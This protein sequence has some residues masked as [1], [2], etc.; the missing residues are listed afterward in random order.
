MHTQST[1]KHFSS[2]VG[3]S[4]I[5]NTHLCNDSERKRHIMV[6]RPRR[7]WSYW[8]H[9]Q[10]IRLLSAVGNSIFRHVYWSS[11]SERLPG[12]PTTWKYGEQSVWS[13]LSVMFARCSCPSQVVC[14]TGFA[15]FKQSSSSFGAVWN[16]QWISA[17]ESGRRG[18][19]HWSVTFDHHV[20][21][22]PSVFISSKTHFVFKI[23]TA[24]TI[25]KSD[26]RFKRGK[27]NV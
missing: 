18:I 13:E 7:R 3:G 23:K 22:P 21:S 6:Q 24:Q 19:L 1:H 25:S 4:N 14:F 27:I 17:I 8:P 2:W 10:F 20:R 12:V 5:G 15:A 11:G 16:Y 9:V 26:I